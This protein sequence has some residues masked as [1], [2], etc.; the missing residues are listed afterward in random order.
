MFDFYKDRREKAV[1]F[2]T[3]LGGSSFFRQ[4]RRRFKFV[5]FADNDK[6]KQG[7]F[8]LGLKVL[9]AEQIRDIVF[10]RVI[11]ASDYYAEIYQQLIHELS[12]P[13]DK[14]S[15]FHEFPIRNSLSKIFINYFYRLKFQLICSANSAVS[16]IFYHL[17][18]QRAQSGSGLRLLPICWLDEYYEGKVHIFKPTCKAFVYGPANIGE[19]QRVFE[20]LL[21]EMALYHFEHGIC[22]STSRTVVLPSNNLVMERVSSS[23]SNNADYAGGQV[24]FHSSYRALVHVA[25]QTTPLDRGILINGVSETN[26]YHCLLEMLSQLYFVK[27]LPENYADTPLLI[28]AHSRNIKSIAAILTM[29][30]LPQNI[31]YLSSAT[32]YEVRSLY[33]VTSPCFLVTNFKSTAKFQVKDYYA[34]EDSL[35]FLR[36][37]GLSCVEM[38]ELSQTP[39]RIFLA[40]KQSLRAYNQDE[41]YQLLAGYGFSEVYLEDLSFKQQVELIKQ[42]EV[43]VG[44]TGAAWSNLLF[45]TSGTKALCWMPEEFGDFAC[46]SHLAALYGVQLDYIRYYTGVS[47]TRALYYQ[48][49]SI[50]LEQVKQWLMQLN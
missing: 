12:Y 29:M 45:A 7:R 32:Q 4:Q 46:F 30:E 34:D 8:Y 5:A 26:Y 9:S 44:P 25:E 31:I 40:R 33:L 20:V 3:G 41:I 13:V 10:D 6:K 15:V 35:N 42:A 14:V 28:S 39:K 24:V 38:S 19:E 17:T 48:R 49:Y 50:D 36:K 2:G 18:I 43:I 16:K 11:I 37:V 47:E 21:P 23:D 22:A 27:Q 1:I